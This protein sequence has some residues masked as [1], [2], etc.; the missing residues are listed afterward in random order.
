[1][2]IAN[3]VIGAGEEVVLVIEGQITHWTALSKDGKSQDV[4]EIL[5]AGGKTRT[6][7]DKLKKASYG[8]KTSLTL[9][10]HDLEDLEQLVPLGD[11]D[12]AM[13]ARLGDDAS[14]AAVGLLTKVFIHSSSEIVDLRSGEVSISHVAGF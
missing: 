5:H 7:L 4:Q 9:T 11:I 14:F 3:A 10:D 13:R 12:P 8:K 2:K 1:L 6:V